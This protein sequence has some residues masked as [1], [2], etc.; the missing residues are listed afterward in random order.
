MLGVT[1]KNDLLRSRF[2]LLPPQLRK[3]LSLMLSIVIFGNT[4]TAVHWLGACLVFGGAVLYT[5]VSCESSGSSL[6]G[7]VIDAS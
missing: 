1:H 7:W 5:Q 2:V 6:S 4:F 3:F